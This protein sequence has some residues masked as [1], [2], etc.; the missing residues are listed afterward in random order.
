MN[1]IKNYK[2]LITEVKLIK[3]NY[4]IFRTPL[5]YTKKLCNNVYS[6]KEF[7]TKA[8]ILISDYYSNGVDINNL[9]GMLHIY[10]KEDSNKK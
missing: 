3:A 5:K 1:K 6:K 2:D 8:F 10:S 4:H 9:T 7:R